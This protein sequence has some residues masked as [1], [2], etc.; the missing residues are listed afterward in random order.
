MQRGLRPWIPIT[1]A[2][3]VAMS[4]IAV[5][6]WRLIGPGRP[7][8]DDAE[9]V[10]RPPRISPDYLGITLPPNIAPLNFV[11]HEDARDLGCAT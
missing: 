5:G 6:G 4:A 11:V 2:V 9:D 3:L 10:P 7:A 1:A 8:V